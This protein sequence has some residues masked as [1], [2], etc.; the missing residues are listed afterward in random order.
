MGGE[1]GARHRGRR[2][3]RCTAASGLP[4]LARARADQQYLFVNGRHRARPALATRCAA[5]TTTCCTASASPV[6]ALFLRIA[7]S[8]VDVNVHPTKIEVR[9]RDGRAVHQAVLHAVEASLASSRTGDAA[10]RCHRGDD[11]RHAL[12]LRTG[13]RPVRRGPAPG[14]RPG[15]RLPRLARRPGR[16]RRER[17]SRPAP[18][19]PST[20][21]LAAGPRHGAAAVASTCWPRTRSGLVIVDMHAAHERIV[22]ERLKAQGS[23]PAPADAT[24][25]DTGDLHRHGHRDGGWR[26]PKSRRCANLGWR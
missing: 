4:D 8:L 5:P 17:L 2:R 14:S 11:Q 24:A 21:R 22:Y 1:P 15:K 18:A 26:R 16:R 13:W 3:S 12:A 9:F 20:R 6:Y 23:G 10:R 7:P 19:P 25:A